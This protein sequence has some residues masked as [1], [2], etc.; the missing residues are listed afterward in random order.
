M[1]LGKE[2]LRALPAAM[3]CVPYELSRDLI[4]TAM[5]GRLR[6][7]EQEHGRGQGKASEHPQ[8]SGGQVEASGQ[9]RTGAEPLREDARDRGGKAAVED[10]DRP[11]IP[12]AQRKGTRTA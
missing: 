2:W 8:A 10:L 9:T 6:D 12:K 5:Q 11:K 3:L 4:H 1:G 7:K